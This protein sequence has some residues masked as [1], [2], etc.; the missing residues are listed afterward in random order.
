[1]SEKY[2]VRV[3]GNKVFFVLTDSL[4]DARDMAAEHAKMKKVT[5]EIL[6]KYGR[7]YKL[8]ETV[9]KG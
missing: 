6:I 8:F 9:E 4:K 3:K 7:G 1:M 5:M 2:K